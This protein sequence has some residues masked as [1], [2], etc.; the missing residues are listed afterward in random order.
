MNLR[1]G[2]QSKS[3]QYPENSLELAPEQKNK[4]HTIIH[5]SFFI[6]NAFSKI[7]HLNGF[8]LAEVLITL[9]IIGVVAAMTLPALVQKQ[10]DKI[11]VTKLKKAY[12]VISQ[13]YL[14]ARNENGEIN[15]WG[16][17]GNITNSDRD[18]NG[19]FD[20][21]VYDNSELFGSKLIPYMKVTSTCYDRGTNCKIPSQYNLSVSIRYNKNTT[22][23]IKLAD[24]TVFLGGWL[25][26]INCTQTVSCGD[27]SVDVNGPENKPN[28][29]GKDVFYFAIYQNKIVPYG[30]NTGSATF[31]KRCKNG[32]DG[33][34]CTAWVIYN[35]NLDY[36]KCPDQLSWDGNT[37]CK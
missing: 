29:V 28:T 3:K 21:S 31:D 19:V 22:T 1:G 23:Q 18:E 24:G 10:Q 8:T 15:N 14:M 17:A 9:G 37:K 27:F 12:S 2:G 34:G 32:G 5:K 25:A 16:F 33:Y 36:L 11:T 26:N 6:E 20:S 4:K 7:N 13:A 35:E 30:G